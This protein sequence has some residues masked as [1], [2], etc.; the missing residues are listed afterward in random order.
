MAETLTYDATPDTVSAADNLTT[1]EQ[2]SLQV[3]EQL[4]AEQEGL[5][6]GKYKNAEELEKAYVNLQQKLGNK[7]DDT[8]STQTDD[9]PEAATESTDDDTINDDDQVDYS[10]LET[11]WS[12]AVEGEFTDETVKAL[13]NLKNE[14]LVNMHLAYRKNVEDNYI[15]QRSLTKKEMAELQDVAG[16]P[17]GYQNMIKWAGETLDKNEVDMFNTAINRGDPLSCFFAIRSLSFRYEDANGKTGVMVTG[18]A[19]TERGN[20]Y[21]SQAEVVEAMSDPRYDKDPAYRQDVMKKLER[22]NVEF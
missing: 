5:L 15:Q 11:A 3:G 22:S 1:D 21:R 16:G 6:A 18:K 20:T 9:E 4:V 13:D 2:D 8:E 17:E 7:S 10:T 14:D 12:E 19:P